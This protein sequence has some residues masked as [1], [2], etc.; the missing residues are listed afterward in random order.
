MR[1]GANVSPVAVSDMGI[2]KNYRNLTAVERDH[3]VDP[4][5]QVKVNGVIDHFAAIHEMHFFMGIHRSSH[6]LPWHREMLLRFE[7]ELQRFH[8][9]VT[10][11]YWDSTVDRSPSDPLWANSFLGQFNSAWGLGRALGSAT[12]PTPQVQTNQGRGTYDAF[13]PELKT[14]IHNWPHVWVEGVMGQAASPGD[15]VFYRHHCWI[16]LLWVRWQHA[17]AGAPF[18]SS[19]SLV[20]PY[21][22]R[23]GLTRT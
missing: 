11:P 19:G 7:R 20:P 21:R 5:L 2:R 8:P 12:L 15:P 14:V 13:W 23:S 18:V 17:H 4:L 6:F 16:D 10:I 3:F 22:S 9:D 1:S